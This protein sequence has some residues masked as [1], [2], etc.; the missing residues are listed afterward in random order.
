MVRF[1]IYV[2]VRV[3]VRLRHAVRLAARPRRPGGAPP[4]QRSSVDRSG[5]KAGARVGAAVALAIASVAP[6]AP[7]AAQ[8]AP[9]LPPT[10]APTQLRPLHDLDGTYLWL[11]PIAALSFDRGMLDGEFGGMLALTRVREHDALATTGLTLAATRRAATEVGIVALEG[12]AGVRPGHAPHLGVTVGPALQF[13]AT[14]HPRLAATASLWTMVG[15]TLFLRGLATADGVEV[16][17]GLAI[18]L[19]A[20]R[21]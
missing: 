10:S 12:I 18:L 16:S 4:T 14:A 9:S 21:W 19:P 1:A 7:A 15:P 20:R 17:A 6:A 13:Q 2:S 5:A 11:G 8:P 3:N